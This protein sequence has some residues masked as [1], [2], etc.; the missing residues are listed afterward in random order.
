MERPRR[1]PKRRRSPALPSHRI[2]VRAARIF[3]ATYGCALNVCWHFRGPWFYWAVRPRYQTDAPLGG[4]V[5]SDTLMSLDLEQR[6]EFMMALAKP[7]VAVNGKLLGQGKPEDQGFEHEWPTVFAYLTDDIWED[8][9]G[10]ERST[11]LIFAEDVFKCCL[12][13]K[14]NDCTLWASGRTLEDLLSGLESRLVDPEADWRK[15]KP[16]QPRKRS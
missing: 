15:R 12:I 2:E 1:Q 11:L 6:K 14:D 7:R 4:R 5:L 9:S 3:L 10:R 8:G 16:P 13:D